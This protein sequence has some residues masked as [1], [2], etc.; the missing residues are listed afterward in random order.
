MSLWQ[1]AYLTSRSCRS[2]SSSP[3]S[4]EESL[5]VSESE[6][7]AAHR[8]KLSDL[9]KFTA[10]SDDEDDEA[11]GGPSS[12]GTALR[13]KN[14]IQ[15]PDV[16]VPDITE[17]GADEPLEKIGTVMSIIDNVVIVKGSSSAVENKAAQRALDS[18]SLLVFEDRKV[19]GYVSR[20]LF[21]VCFS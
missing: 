5:D 3:S 14:E 11:D 15:E 1:L 7:E 20:P 21:D 6:D 16:V 18:E 19:L 9:N 17:V 13:S 4:S 10:I 12:K 2:S 8:D